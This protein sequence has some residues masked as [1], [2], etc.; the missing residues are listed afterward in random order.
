M[1][2][3]TTYFFLV[4]DKIECM[5]D[6]LSMSITSRM[7]EGFKPCTYYGMKLKVQEESRNVQILSHELMFKQDFSKKLIDK[8][9]Q[10]GKL[11]PTSKD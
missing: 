7:S 2:N 1:S 10:I 9:E 8:L 6:V 4:S 11:D 3:K 5:N